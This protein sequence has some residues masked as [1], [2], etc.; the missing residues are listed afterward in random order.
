MSSDLPGDWEPSPE[1]HA[2]RYTGLVGSVTKV[3]R[4]GPPLRIQYEGPAQFPA[5]G[6]PCPSCGVLCSMGV[7][8]D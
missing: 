6:H 7:L 4:G 2:P 8:H 1:R 5:D 3:R